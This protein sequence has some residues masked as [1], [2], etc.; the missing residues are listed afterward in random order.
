[1]REEVD[2]TLTVTAT[3]ADVEHTGQRQVF[4]VPGQDDREATAR[5]L[6]SLFAGWLEQHQPAL[7]ITP[8]T[9]FEGSMVAP[10][11]LVVS[12]YMFDND[13]YELGLSWHIMVPPD[14]WSELYL[15]PKDSLAPTRAFRLSSWSAALGGED[16]QFTEVAAPT[17][18]V[19]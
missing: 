12:H 10:R 11:L 19:R 5:E 3:R 4:V 9:G 8:E 7:G 17:E 18:I 15:R 2:A 14:D 13:A 6:L 1:V 16:V